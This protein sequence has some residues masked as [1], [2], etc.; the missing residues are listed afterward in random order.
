[1]SLNGPMV[2]IRLSEVYWRSLPLDL[3][4][5]GPGISCGLDRSTRVDPPSAMATRSLGTGEP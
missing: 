4:G 2:P 3:R 5:V 1:M